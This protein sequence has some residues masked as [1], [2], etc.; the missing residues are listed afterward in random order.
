MKIIIVGGGIGGLSAAVGLL[1]LGIDVTVLERAD[2][3]RTAGAGLNI[4]PNGGRALGALGLKN[5]YDDI[6]VRLMKY[7]NYSSAGV[8]LRTIDTSDWG[9][10]FGAYA[11]GMHRRALN[12]ML[13]DAVGYEN[14]RF[15]T[16]IV[17]VRQE[18]DKVYC[19]ASD[20]TTLEADAVIGADGVHSRVRTSLVGDVA[21]R[22]NEYHAFRCRAIF[23]ISETSF[24]RDAQTG[25]YDEDGFVSVI[26]IGK[27]KAYW[28]GSVN[29]AR[30]LDQFVDTV[31]RWKVGELPELVASTSKGVILE[32]HL[33]DFG[34]IPFR[35]T[36]GRVTLMGDAAH[37]VMPDL[38]QGATQTLVDAAALQAAFTETLNPVVAFQ[39]YE[40]RRRPTAD[41]TVACSARGNFMG[42][43]RVNPIAIRYV[44][45]VEAFQG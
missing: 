18:G 1:K 10:R 45:E 6:S 2:A 5:E 21:L 4:W 28:F 16:E 34:G 19:T 24:A 13:A 33:Q 31:S 15:N 40:Q 3:I 39:R 7:I 17:S 9:A 32:N 27:S 38:A 43:R 22:E 41:H 25:A 8:L 42:G 11:V 26:P 20:D 35:W 14:I 44:N 36:H 23:D 29:G 30:T 37:A 12:L